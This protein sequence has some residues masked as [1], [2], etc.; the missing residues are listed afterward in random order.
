[1]DKKIMLVD[2]AAFMR[3]LIKNTLNKNGYSR[4]IEASDGEIAY[5][6]YLKE[7]PDLVIMDITMPNMSGIEALREIKKIDPYA[8]VI[9][10]SAI[11]QEAM[12]LKAIKLGALDFIVKPFKGDMILAA[13]E[14]ALAQHA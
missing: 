3:S 4:I 9:M 8:K 14:K 6:L 7:K 5:S 10:C 1:M 2:D 13:V 11:G 12:M